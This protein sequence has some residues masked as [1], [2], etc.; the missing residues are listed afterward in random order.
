MIMVSL[1]VFALG[2]HAWQ[3]DMHMYFFAALAM[4][5]AFCDWRALLTAAGTVAVHHLVFNFV[6]PSAV[7]PGGGD[8]GRVIL[9]AVIVVLET[10]VLIWLTANLVAA[11][12]A[13]EKAAEQTK[14]A[15][16]EARRADDARQ[17]AERK[18]SVERR[19]SIARLAS[20]FEGRVAGIVR[21]LSEKAGNMRDQTELASG[22][23]RTASGRSQTAAT[24]AAS[25]MEN[26]QSV[27][28][29]THE[30]SASIDE[31]A[32]QLA[33]ASRVSQA[34]AERARE[35]DAT[36]AA[37][38]TTTH[39]IGDVVDLINAIAA[40]TNLLALNATIEAARAGEAGRG[41]SI[42]AA[43]V[44]QLAN[45]TSK[46]TGDIATQIEA[47][48]STSAETAQAIGAIRTTIEEISRSSATIS[49][50]IDQQS[51]AV[52]EISEKTSAASSATSLVSDVTQQLRA[53]SDQT[54]AAAGAT[55]T[56]ARDLQDMVQR[57]SGE[58]E[59]FISH[60]R[61]A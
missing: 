39:R 18:A 7:F 1:L 28:A 37:L 47:V 52:R 26:V 17:D 61:A 40:Q 46:A 31:I 14:E 6:L 27:A 5:A 12:G 33:D 21:I 42:V 22:A 2:G 56:A 53:T 55:D 59:G 57:L 30:L 49:A 41:F 44:K 50:A 51:E 29:A 24:G 38:S 9:H 48:Q 34:A 36:V 15:F 23:A 54:L 19:E 60:I 32:R 20:D 4:L 13:A 3:I 10:A 43:E 11:L 16:A 58:V 45:Q 25:T 8:F 35:A